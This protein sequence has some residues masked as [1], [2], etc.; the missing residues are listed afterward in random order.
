M[1]TKHIAFH[2][3]DLPCTEHLRTMTFQEALV[4]IVGNKTDIL[5]FLFMRNRKR[6]LFCQATRFI[7]FH[8]TEREQEL[9]EHILFH[10]I[11]DIR[12]IFFRIKT[13]FQEI[14]ITRFIVRDLR[15]MPCCKIIRTKLACFGKECAEL[16]LLI[17]NDTRI[18]CSRTLI[19]TNKIRNDLLCKQIVIVYDMK[20]NAECIGNGFRIIDSSLGRVFFCFR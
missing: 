7:L 4:I 16:Q 8:T 2:I 18:R 13:F 5:T 3:N 6:H 12:L 20:L 9:S 1:L 17:A 14:F 10:M 19:F 15:I 11:Q